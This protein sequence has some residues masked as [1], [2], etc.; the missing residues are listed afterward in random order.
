MG[1]GPWTIRNWVV[2]QEVRGCLPQNQSLVPKSSGT[3]GLESWGE[4]SPASQPGPC[5]GA[6]HG[7]EI[8]LARVPFPKQGVLRCVAHVLKVILNR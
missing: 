1:I 4:A 6:I 8:S 7:A 5:T 2:Q 3:I